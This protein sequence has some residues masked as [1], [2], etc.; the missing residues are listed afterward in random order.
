MLL[1]S[2]ESELTEV[3]IKTLNFFIH[4]DLVWLLLAI[5]TKLS[6]PLYE[7]SKFSFEP[8]FTYTLYYNKNTQIVFQIKIIPFFFYSANAAD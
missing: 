6:L 1:S 5:V 7:S 4:L 3:K 2:C 8:S